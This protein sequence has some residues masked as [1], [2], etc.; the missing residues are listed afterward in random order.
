MTAANKNV[1]LIG[2]VL[3]AGILIYRKMKKNTEKETTS[4]FSNASG[5]MECECYDKNG[6]Y[7]GKNFCRKKQH[8]DCESCCGSRGKTPVREGEL[9]R[10]GGGSPR[11]TLRRRF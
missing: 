3:I 9:N 7:S 11:I 5:Q 4:G 8:A 2:G 10:S 6:V 1:L